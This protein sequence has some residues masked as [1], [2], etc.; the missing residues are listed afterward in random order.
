MSRRTIV[1]G[2]LLLGL[3]G[4][5]GSG[6]R[7]VAPGEQVVIRRFGRL[8][9]PALAPG[10]HFGFPAGIDRQDRLRTDE[11]R[12]LE[13][14]RELP[15]SSPE[16]A[17]EEFLTSDLNLARIRAIVQYR[18]THLPGFLLAAEHAERVLARLAE[19]ALTDSLARRGI[20]EVLR[21]GRIRVAAEV[22]SRLRQAVGRYGLG[23]SILAVNL[24]DARPP[25]EVASEFASV[26]SAESHRA[27]RT[28]DALRQREVTIRS[29]QAQAQAERQRA[30]ADNLRLLSTS[31]AQADRF[32][33]ILAEAR[34]A[35]GLTAQRLY[36]DTVRGLLQGVRRKI[37]VPPGEAVD[38][39]VL[40]VPPQ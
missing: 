8:L 35:R 9:E 30:A 15:G 18:V 4:W 1:G 26:Q 17:A 14:G 33:A 32:L 36:L 37:V 40:G 11:V 34:G 19:A 20:D 28:H 10:L 25:A 31:K 12:Q 6:V 38:L 7:I 16:P 3:L 39:T 2:V 23:V 5:I 29:A 13:V 22:E 24:I 27:Q 21:S